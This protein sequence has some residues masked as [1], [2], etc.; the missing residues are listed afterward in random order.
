[1]PILLLCG[2][3]DH[4]IGPDFLHTCEVAFTKAAPARSVVGGGRLPAV[5]AR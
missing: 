5:G 4:V 2:M 1:M 3:D